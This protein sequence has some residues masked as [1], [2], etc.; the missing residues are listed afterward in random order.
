MEKGPLRLEDEAVCLHVW[1]VP[2]ASRSGIVG[3]HGDKLKVQVSS[4]PEAGRANEAVMGLL[5]NALGGS[6]RLVR[7]MRSRHKVFEIAAENISSAER[8]LGLA[9]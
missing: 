1:V 4:P 2:G 5:E 6:V 9:D 8:K 3:L 7:G